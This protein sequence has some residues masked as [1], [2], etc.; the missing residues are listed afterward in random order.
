MKPRVGSVRPLACL[1]GALLAVAAHDAW[2][3]A[4][5]V[6]N[7][8]ISAET[9][10]NPAMISD[11]DPL[12]ARRAATRLLAEAS[13]ALVNFSQ[14]GQFRFEPRVRTDAYADEVDQQLE[15]TDWYLP[16]QGRWSGERTRLGFRGE[17]SREK[18]LGTEFLD[19]PD[20]AL[21]VVDVDGTLRGLNEVRNLATVNPYTEIDFG[22]KSTVR[23]DLRSVYAVYDEAAI[24]ARTD[25]WDWEVGAAY[26]RAVTDRT[27][28]SLRVF[29]GRYKSEDEQNITDKAG[30]ELRFEREVSAQWTVA[31]GVGAEQ[32]DYAYFDP[33]GNLVVGN[34]THPILAL[35]L[36]KRA[37][38]SEFD[39]GISR[40][41]RP[42]S[43]GTVVLRNELIAAWRRE[44]SATVSGGLTLR[45]IDSEALAQI[46]TEREY[47]RAELSIDWS[48]TEVWSLVAGYEH[49][50]WRNVG[51]DTR[52]S[53]N[54]VVV[55]FNFRG[56]ARS[57]Q[58]R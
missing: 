41:A 36:Q 38:R 3:A 37:E 29:G 8:R 39:L 22:E 50:Y 51:L 27:D 35:E 32:T 42:D 47:G 18:I 48:F 5:V 44:L 40:R 17:I 28:M 45:A 33:L 20:G 14:Q 9:N 4:E 49:S 30:I 53:S 1:I 11:E 46:S 15:S 34:E 23:L 56:K 31:G 58:R 2:S 25:F 6:P 54:S 57:D 21:D 7:V 55:G 12:G 10:D 24:Q 26:V 13:F 19:D 52:A 43:F 16:A